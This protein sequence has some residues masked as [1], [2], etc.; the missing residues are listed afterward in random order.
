MGFTV[1]KHPPSLWRRHLVSRVSREIRIFSN[2][3]T[4]CHKGLCSALLISHQRN[5][6][7]HR[8]TANDSHNPFALQQQF[9]WTWIHIGRFLLNKF[10]VMKIF[11]NCELKCLCHILTFEWIFGYEYYCLTPT[12]LNQRYQKVRKD[13]SQSIRNISRQ[14]SGI[15]LV[16]LK[17]NLQETFADTVR[18]SD[19]A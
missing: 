18:A 12:L 5:V 2:Q 3:V 4:E 1:R 15:F 14:H 16:F 9:Y 17:V 8:E 11:L 10:H 19:V 13:Y 7:F 6:S